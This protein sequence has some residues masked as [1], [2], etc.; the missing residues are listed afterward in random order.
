MRDA[1]RRLLNELE[2]QVSKFMFR[3]RQSLCWRCWGALRGSPV[4]ATRSTSLF[5]GAKKGALEG[6]RGGGG[7]GGAL[8]EESGGS[9]V[10]GGC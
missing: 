6:A 7:E 3:A 10:V 9:Y 8:T 4:A 5:C 2:G 1:A